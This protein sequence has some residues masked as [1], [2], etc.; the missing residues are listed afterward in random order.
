MK[1]YFFGLSALALCFVAFLGACKDDEIDTEK[2]VITLMEPS[3]GDTISLADEDSIHIEF[4]VSDNDGVHGVNV[5]VLDAT[6]GVSVYSSENHAE[7]NLYNFHD[8]FVPT[9]VTQ[10]KP[11][12]LVIDASDHSENMTNLTTTF[13]LQQ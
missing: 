12:T 2:P 13:Y 1:N 4:S 11:Y 9:N 5:S 10:L 3:A 7:T 6:S 8:H